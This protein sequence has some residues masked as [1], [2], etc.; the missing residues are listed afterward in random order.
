MLVS[1]PWGSHAPPVITELI[2]ETAIFYPPLNP[3][4]APTHDPSKDAGILTLAYFLGHLRRGVGQV[5]TF[6]PILHFLH[7][8]SFNHALSLWCLHVISMQATHI[9]VSST[10][11]QTIPSY[12]RM[13]NS[14]TNISTLTNFTPKALQRSC[15]PEVHRT[16]TVLGNPQDPP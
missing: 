6:T 4:W 12:S 14:R 2:S 10:S 16:K 3:Q 5:N 9:P 1:L 7:L 13:K 15:E 8:L 11:K